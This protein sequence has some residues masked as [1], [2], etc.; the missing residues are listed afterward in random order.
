M[1]DANEHV[2]YVG[3]AKNLRDRVGSYFSQPLGYTRKMDGLIESLL[4]I[5]VEV[6]GSEIEALLLES[7]LIRR[8]QPRYNTALRSHEHYPFIRVDVANPWPRVSSG[9][10]ARG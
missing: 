1:R 4:R 5:Q 8:Y 7:Q 3:K 2:V 10:G 9:Q 6:V